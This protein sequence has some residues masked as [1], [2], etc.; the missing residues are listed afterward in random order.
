M[1]NITSK[2]GEFLQLFK[3]NLKREYAQNEY[4]K[5]TFMVLSNNYRNKLD[6]V[7]NNVLFKAG[8]SVSLV[9]LGT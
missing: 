1:E 5:C 9:S 6:L 8:K 3:H 7:N 4:L 2:I